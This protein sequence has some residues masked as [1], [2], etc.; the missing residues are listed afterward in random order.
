MFLCPTKDD[1]TIRAATET[2][3]ATVANYR[4]LEDCRG[5][6]AAVAEVSVVRCQCWNR[7]TDNGHT[8]CVAVAVTALG[9]Q[10][11]RIVYH[12]QLEM[13]RII[14]GGKRLI[15][16][17]FGNAALQLVAGRDDAK[18]SIDK[19]LQRLVAKRHKEDVSRRK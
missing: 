3:S 6:T 2:P 1:P 5:T 9:R 15:F 10:A 18:F 16:M 11:Q 8:H 4:L 17:T 13:I 19:V 7:E 12:L 14:S